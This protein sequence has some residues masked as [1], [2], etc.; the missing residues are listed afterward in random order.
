MFL[1]PPFGRL[2]PFQLWG[3][4]SVSNS[5]KTGLPSTSEDTQRR[6][7]TKKL[8]S[9]A[10]QLLR[11]LWMR[12]VK[13]TFLLWNSIFSI[14]SLNF[15]RLAL[16]S[17]EPQVFLSLHYYIVPILFWR[18]ALF[19]SKLIKESGNQDLLVWSA[20]AKDLRKKKSKWSE[21]SPNYK[22]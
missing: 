9:F 22:R 18:I 20:N 21:P 12:T 15:R 2:R 3:S 7:D 5:L 16:L 13:P 4:L 11:W 17:M 8:S 19:A 1:L 6:M 14:L 10:W